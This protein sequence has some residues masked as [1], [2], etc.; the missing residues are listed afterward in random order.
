MDPARKYDPDI[1]PETRPDLRAIPGGGETTDDRPARGNLSLVSDNLAE[2]EKEGTFNKPLDD[3]KD[4]AEQ[5]RAGETGSWKDN[6][7]EDKKAA[8]RGFSLR[9]GSAL[10]SVVV[11]LL[12]LLGLGGTLLTPG[13]GIV[14]MKEVLTGDLNDQLAAMDI[15]SD[16]VFRAKLSNMSSGVC[17][18]VQIKC[19]FST[20]SK[21][22]VERFK[23]AGFVIPEDGVKDTVF[24]RQRITQMTAPDGSVIRNPADL[25]NARKKSPQVR[26]AMNR[27]FNPLYYGLSDKVAGAFLKSNKTGKQKKVNGNNAEERRQALVDATSGEKAQGATLQ[28]ENGRNY[29]LDE[30]NNRVYETGTDADRV[31]FNELKATADAT[32]AQLENKPRVDGKAVGS[33]LG[34]AIKGVSVIGAVDSACTVYNTARAVGAAAK[35]ARSMQL[36]QFAMI[37]NTTADAIKA[38]DA[39]PEEVEFV[40][41]MLT[42]T[43]TNKTTIDETTGF[44]VDNPFYGKSAYDSPGYKTAAY[45]D[46]PSLN[47][48]SQ[49]YMVGGGLSGTLSGVMSTVENA[50]TFNNGGGSIRGTCGFIQSPWV[51]AGGLVLGV[52]AAIGSF[53]IATGISIAASVAVSFALPFLEAML[54][55]IVAGTVIGEDIKGVDAGNAAFA[56]TAAMLGGVAQ[57]R[58]MQPLTSEGISNYMAATR[59]TRNEMIAAERYEASKT[60]FDINNQY[61]F[62]GSFARSLYPTALHAQSSVASA[63]TSI[64]S[65]LGLGLTS[66]TKPYSVQ[67]E[68]VYNEERFSKCTDPGY[69]ELGID[70]DIF[71]NVRYGLTDAE[72][73][74]DTDTVV[75]FMLSS[76]NIDENGKAQ[77]SYQEF[78]DKCVNRT[79][80]WGE[81]SE[82]GGSIGLEC[83]DGKIETFANISYFRVYTMDNSINEAMDL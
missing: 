5:L 48:R 2:Q 45:N 31:R 8:V 27:V 66:I 29:M 54:A 58:G 55:D 43:D 20:M 42:A 51:R 76:G 40:G 28:D 83:V 65:V 18:G 36:I 56:G 34:G 47:A 9:K 6:T 39:T 81:T 73:A 52:F 32:G 57:N 69:E 60:P 13:L 25:A 17:V 53:G 63:I 72:L 41:N 80:G 4:S 74:M 26:S 79:D 38:G 33:V 75:E 77:G 3:Q 1:E 15:R 78:L 30:K 11:I 50:I 46:A 19:K 49:Q 24:G 35:I 7:H 64:G 12:G 23:K 62:L 10:G 16:H 59:D 71:C 44:G 70:A 21:R 61:S 14:Q 68:D 22:Q 67:A 82:E 37:I